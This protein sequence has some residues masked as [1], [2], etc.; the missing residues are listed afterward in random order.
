M[1]VII[2]PMNGGMTYPPGYE[3]HESAIARR[4]VALA[5]QAAVLANA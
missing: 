1:P 5:R 4:F 3:D 2:G